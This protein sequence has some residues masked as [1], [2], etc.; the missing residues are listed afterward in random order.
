MGVR[1]KCQAI[2]LKHSRHTAYCLWIIECS[3]CRDVRHARFYFQ[4]QLLALAQV[5]V[6]V[7]TLLDDGPLLGADLKTSSR[8]SSPRA[9]EEVVML[10]AGGLAASLQ[11]SPDGVEA[12][13]TAHE[14][15]LQD[16]CSSG[17]GVAEPL[18]QRWA[19]SAPLGGRQALCCS[20]R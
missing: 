8:A 13:A 10:E 2:C 4:P 16:L 12:E 1:E 19:P 3:C 18:L 6:L 5:S 17:R 14:L 7:C 11:M 9:P 20:R 15:C